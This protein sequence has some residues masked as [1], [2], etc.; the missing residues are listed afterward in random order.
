LQDFFDGKQLNK[1]INPD[2]AVVYGATVQASNMASMDN[3]KVQHIAFLDVTPY[4]LA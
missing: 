4:L 1:S 2:E 3:E